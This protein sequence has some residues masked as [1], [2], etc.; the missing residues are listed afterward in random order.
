[1]HEAGAQPPARPAGGH[2]ARRRCRCR[3]GALHPH[4]PDLLAARRGR[5]RALD[6]Q[7]CVMATA[8]RITHRTDYF[9]EEPV[10]SSYG[11]LHMLPRELPVQRCRSAELSISPTP[12]LARERTDFFGNRVAYFALHEPH[13][14]LNVTVTSVVEVE[15]RSAELSL[16]GQQSWEQVRDAVAAG[17]DEI[18]ADIVQY[19]LDS[20]RAGS[21]GIY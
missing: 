10:S 2:A 4:H 8:Y 15:D 19:V 20:P 21:A 3:R 13:Q 9:Y 5:C 18:P 6:H 17:G 1:W 11:Q 12:E 7:G 14:H 16:F